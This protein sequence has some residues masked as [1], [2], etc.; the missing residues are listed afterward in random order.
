MVD[1][2]IHYDALAVTSSESASQ[3]M[4]MTNFPVNQESDE[5]IQAGLQLAEQM[6]KVF[7]FCGV[8]S[9]TGC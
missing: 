1:Q 2:G 8:R 9:V 5:L 6:R 7:T 4:D 3:D